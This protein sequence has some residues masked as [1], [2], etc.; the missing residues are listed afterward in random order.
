MSTGS[1]LL[2]SF[3][4]LEYIV[5]AKLLLLRIRDYFP[6]S[7]LWLARVLLVQQK[8][9]DGLSSIL[10][11][12]LKEVVT[13]TLGHLGDLKKVKM[14]WMGTDESV[15]S[16]IVSMVHLESGII[17]FRYG[18]VD[19]SKLHFELAEKAS[20]LSLSVSGAMG[21]RTVHQVDPKAQLCLLA[22]NSSSKSEISEVNSSVVRKNQSHDHQVHEASDVLL[23]PRFLEHE[24]EG[25]GSLNPVQQALVLAQCLLIEKN[26]PHD[27]M[28]RWDMAPY[29]EAIDSQSLLLFTIKCF[30][31]LLRIRWEKTRGRTKE[32]ALLMMDKLVQGVYEPE[33]KVVERICYCFGVDLPTIPSLR[34]EYADLLVSCG[35]IGEA[36]KIYENL[37]LWDNVIF[38]YRLLEKKAASV[39]LINTRLLERPNDPRLWCSLGDVT[40]NDSCYEKALEVSENKSVRAK[41][42]LARS[43]YNR[44][45]YEKSKLLW[46]S[47]MG[48]NS[49]Y[50]DGW[51]ALG[52]AALKARDLEKAL[53]AFTR[54]VQIDPDN[55]EAWNNIACLHMTKKRNK[56][57]LIA[58]KE[59]LKFKRESWQMW[60]NYSQVAVDSGNFSL[61]LEATQKVLSLTNNKRYDVKLLDDIMLEIEGKNNDHVDSV[62]NGVG[63]LGLEISR[64]TEQLTDM[65]GKILQQIAKSGGSGEIWGLFARWHKLKGDLLMCSEALLK[66]VRSYQG[67]ELWKDEERFKKF[68]RASLEL[69]KVYMEIGSIN[70]G[71]K[72]F[73]AAEM[74]LKSTIKQA[75]SRFSETEEFMELEVFLEKLQAVLQANSHQFT[76]S[77]NKEKS[78]PQCGV[79]DPTAPFVLILDKSIC[80]VPALSKKKCSQ[81]ENCG[82]HTI[83]KLLSH[84][85]RT[86]ADLQ[87]AQITINDGPYL[88]FIG[89]VISSRGIKASSGDIVCVSGKVRSM[90]TKDHY[91]IREYSL[92]LIRDD[93]DD[94]ESACAEGRPY[95]IYPSEGGLNPKLL[96]DTITS[97]LDTLPPD[98]DPIPKNILQMFGLTSLRDAYIGIH[99][100]TNFSE[101]DLARK[102]IIF[103][104]FFYLQLG[105]LYQL[106]EGLGTRIEKDGLLD[107][108]LWKTE[109]NNHGI[110]DLNEED[111]NCENDD[112]DQGSESIASWQANLL[113]EPMQFEAMDAIVHRG[114]YEAAKVVYE[115]ML[116]YVHDHLQCHGNRATISLTGH[117]LGGSLSLLVNL[118]LLIRGQVHLSSLLPVVTFGAPWVMCGGDRLLQNL[119]LPRNHL[120]G[121]T[122][123]RDIVPRA[124]SCNYPTRVA[125]FLKVV[126]G[127]FRNHPCLNNQNLLYAPMGEFLILQP[128]AKLSPSHDLL[129]QGSGLYVLRSQASD[130]NV[131]NKLTRVAQ[132]IFLNTPH[133]LEILTDRC[134][135]G[136]EGAILRDHDVDTYLISIRKV[137]SQELKRVRRMRRQQR[138]Q[139]W[140]HMV[141]VNGTHV[142]LLLN[143]GREWWRT[144]V[145][146]QNMHL[147]VVV[148]VPFARLW[149]IKAC[150]WIRFRLCM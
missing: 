11:E 138:R 115:E 45:E 17:D 86:Y 83:R 37:E 94:D 31:D 107:K 23:T 56:E 44:G 39:E 33:P 76:L 137:I 147:V 128:D 1:D 35:L 79:D 61:A 117:S 126:N 75:A 22:G 105:R 116:P 38:C 42:S 5:F 16:D 148:L 131:A 51:F 150:N 55:G 142:K 63:E 93:D 81:L 139:F 71:R 120:R 143:S 108:S 60:E 92:D 32:R 57:A 29:I 100:P 89:K 132:S 78:E 28:Q 65:I 123:H 69:C 15:L 36:V 10:F 125:H 72:E 113:F 110:Q 64:E 47:A 146:T 59:A 98:I 118:M 74:H 91:E 18:H 52:A 103:D 136:S 101:A 67:S 24:N 130:P 49:L 96:G 40:N 140:W 88:I 104:E 46:E 53:D 68:A 21:F 124:F 3:S 54:A 114:I 41:R 70:G 102:R 20:R 8:L 149:I 129:P 2:A 77:N 73:S 13:E 84:F 135:Y 82:F 9:L 87:N 25:S 12:K 34:K 80:C 62:V 66:H 127:N 134:A 99:W 85:P 122:M 121:I 4:N 27:E 145:A 6:T 14:Y 50:R 106:L 119:G 133:P 111:D 7:S 112:G 97:V 19:S 109:D 30:C 43:A 58:F 26:T 141:V 48:L 95:P 90:R 144:V